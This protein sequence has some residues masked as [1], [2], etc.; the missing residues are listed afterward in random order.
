MDK[1]IKIN[2]NEIK[3]LTQELIR[4][5][6]INPPGNVDACAEFIV[7]WLNDN[8][9]SATIEK[10]EHVSNVVAKVGKEN[11]R[12][13]LW[14]G[15]FDVVP[16]GD[17]KK[18]HADPFEANE[19][20]GYIYGRAASDMKSGVAA[21]MFG[22]AEIKKRQIDLNGQIIFMG[23]GD[24]ET[25]STNGTLA[26]LKKYG[27]QYD[28]A[29]VPEPTNFCIESAQRGLRWI[30]VSVIGKACHAGRPHV[31]K[32]AIEHAAKIIMALKNIQFD[33]H[34]D[35]FEEGLKEPSLS[36]TL[37]SGGIKENV[38]PES[39]TLLI[40]RR[41]LP[42]ETEEKIMTEIEGAVKNAA[43]E[44]FVDTVRIVNKGWNPYVIDQSEEILQKTIASY[45]KITGDEPVVRGKGGCTD[46]SH[47]FDAGIPVVILGPGN[48]DESHTTNEKV[49][50]KRIA[51]TAEIMIDSAIAFLK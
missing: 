35:L 11:G 16:P 7:K 45:R 44:G 31:G 8:G 36:I 18:W 29:V 12:K 4:I 43:E 41:M 42:G 49:S 50:I 14:N 17:L 25:G 30:E 22:L 13:L 23:I 39:C 26:L 6:S 24:E 48:A 9:I 51:Q 20:D 32:N 33:T 46:A 1:Y 5:P 21:M 3:Q 40:D 37:I 27:N 47:I 15:H 38:I 2:E 19:K 34:H 28:A 10:F